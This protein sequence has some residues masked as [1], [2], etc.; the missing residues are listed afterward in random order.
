MSESEDN[1]D[2]AKDVAAREPRAGSVTTPAWPFILLVVML[3]VGMR[4]FE[5][6]GGSFDNEV[7]YGYAGEA[8][9]IIGGDPLL[10]KFERGKKAYATYCA[11][12]HQPH[13]KGLP[14]QFPP[15]AGSDWVNGVGPN[16]IVRLVLDGIGGPITVNDQTYNNVM[17]PWRPTLNDEQISDIISYIR[18]EPEWGNAGSFVSA[19]EV[20][21]IREATSAHAGTPY[22]ADELLSTPDSN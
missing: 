14:G 12:C 16:R 1:L 13:G 2:G 19:E 15:L 9:P 6:Q 4:Y 22:N 17:V 10:A 5:V 20:K 7:Y 3:W 21:A 11:A 8:P 18:N